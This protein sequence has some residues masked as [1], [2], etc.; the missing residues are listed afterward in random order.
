MR[1]LLLA[2]SERFAQRAVQCP[3]ESSVAL[4]ERSAATGDRRQNAGQS[5]R[6]QPVR[7]VRSFRPLSS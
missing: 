7:Y 5:K 3:N 2:I 4:G 1:T 6:G